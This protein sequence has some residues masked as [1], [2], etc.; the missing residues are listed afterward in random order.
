MGLRKIIKEDDEWM[1]DK[2]NFWDL[3]D[4]IEEGMNY[5]MRCRVIIIFILE[6]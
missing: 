1:R 2:C 3:V 6:G 4:E 5:F